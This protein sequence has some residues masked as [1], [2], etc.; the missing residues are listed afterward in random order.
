MWRVASA[1][2]DAQANSLSGL[3][4]GLVLI[5][6]L[7]G[8]LLFAVRG[9]RVHASSGQRKARS[10][11]YL[12]RYRPSIRWESLA[13]GWAVG[14]L[15]HAWHLSILAAVV[16][17]VISGLACGAFPSSVL[18]I[19]GITGLAVKIVEVATDPTFSPTDRSMVFG[20]LALCL[21]IAWIAGLFAPRR[22]A[23]AIL[24][25]VAMLLADIVV[26]T[27]DIGAPADA[28]T[29][30]RLFLALAVVVLPLA[31][32]L[33]MIAPRFVPSVFAVGL[34]AA[35]IWTITFLGRA[36]DRAPL[37][38]AGVMIVHS[39]AARLSAGRASYGGSRRGS[40]AQW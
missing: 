9:G 29:S 5:G 26:F 25:L 8:I 30:M 18:P 24:P 32:A 19:I 3:I 16:L 2:S 17:A 11:G 40:S 13:T 20:T 14:E 31:A 34:V 37:F 1:A 7:L 22:D 38:V 6:G 33:A 21:P 15:S 39:A 23:L 35:Q 27:A 10:A 12:S 4:G 28:Q 36:S